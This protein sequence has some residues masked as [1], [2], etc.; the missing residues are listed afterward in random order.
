MVQLFNQQI[1]LI[2]QFSFLLSAISGVL[3][4]G[5]TSFP[6]SETL[7]SIYWRGWIVFW[8]YG[9]GLPAHCVDD[10]LLSLV[11]ITYFISTLK[12]P[13]RTI[14]RA[15]PGLSA[16]GLAQFLLASLSTGAQV[17]A[18]SNLVSFFHLVSKFQR[19][20]M[21]LIRYRIL[22]H[23]LCACEFVAF[24]TYLLQ[25][26]RV[27]EYLKINQFTIFNWKI[28]PFFLFLKCFL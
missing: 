13:R 27:R 3:W 2:L 6:F 10:P 7:V 22:S 25:L 24:S 17:A 11:S 20:L 19:L 16:G 4:Y 8:V 14:F 1:L 28:S 12:F 9:K 15:F 18:F 23:F 26:R 5:D 21:L